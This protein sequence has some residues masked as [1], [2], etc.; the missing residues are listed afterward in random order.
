M[1]VAVQTRLIARMLSLAQVAMLNALMAVVQL[2]PPLVK[3]SLHVQKELRDVLTATA[4]AH[5]YYARLW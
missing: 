2:I 3:R 4:V 1:E 5:P